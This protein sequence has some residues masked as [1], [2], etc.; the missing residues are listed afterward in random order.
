MRAATT[1]RAA[2]RNA[3]KRTSPRSNLQGPFPYT[4]PAATLLSWSTLRS[5]RNLGREWRNMRV[6]ELG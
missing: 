4:A 1:Y 3:T 6:G 5:I 2:R